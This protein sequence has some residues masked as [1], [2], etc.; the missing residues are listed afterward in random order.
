MPSP[1][2]SEC[3]RRKGKTLVCIPSSM[4]VYVLSAFALAVDKT[5]IDVRPKSG[6]A[7]CLLNPCKTADE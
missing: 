2:A 7:L 1:R 3:S 4:C 5:L 6:T